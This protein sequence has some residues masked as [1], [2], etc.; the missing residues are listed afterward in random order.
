MRTRGGN[1]DIGHQQ[2]RTPFKDFSTLVRK[3]LFSLKY[4]SCAG[5]IVIKFSYYLLLAG[6]KIIDIVVERGL[7]LVRF[8]LLHLYRRGKF[9]SAQV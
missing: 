8:V 1:C 6:T 2:E 3:I 7:S 5:F 4:K 9:A